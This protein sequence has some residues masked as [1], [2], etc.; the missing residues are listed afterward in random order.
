MI[1][2]AGLNCHAGVAEIAGRHS[3]DRTVGIAE[4]CGL[5]HGLRRQDRITRFVSAQV[6][7]ERGVMGLAMFFAGFVFMLC[8]L[9]AGWVAGK[10]GWRGGMKIAYVYDAA[11]MDKE[12][13]LRR[14][15]MRFQGGWLKG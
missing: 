15:Y 3:G 6:L 5:R 8:L 1:S 7:L 10:G 11:S 14:G 9:L 12:G 13:Y 4:R 2:I